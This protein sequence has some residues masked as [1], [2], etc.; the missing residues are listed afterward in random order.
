MTFEDLKTALAEMDESQLRRSVKMRSMD[1]ADL[2]LVVSHS[3]V[4]FF[5]YVIDAE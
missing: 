3:G 1:E 4:P 2:E 5:V